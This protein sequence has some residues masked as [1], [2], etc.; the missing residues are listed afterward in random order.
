MTMFPGGH[1]EGASERGATL[2][3]QL[4]PGAE[5]GQHG[6]FAGTFTAPDGEESKSFDHDFAHLPGGTTNTETFVSSGNARLVVLADGQ[7]RGGGRKTGSGQ[8]SWPCID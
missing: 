7:F 5:D 4:I 8:F 2:I 3:G 6:R 1:V